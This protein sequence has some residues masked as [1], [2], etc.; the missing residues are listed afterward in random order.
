MSN[1]LSNP[2]ST[3]NVCQVLLKSGFI[4]Q[5]QAKEILKKKL[6]EIDYGLEEKKTIPSD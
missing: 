2:F 5:G 4:S 3:K 6:A 1:D